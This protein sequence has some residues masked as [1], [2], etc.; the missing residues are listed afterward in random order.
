MTLHDMLTM[1]VDVLSVRYKTAPGCEDLVPTKAHMD[2]AG[3]DLRAREAG[4][5]QQ[6]TWAV[7]STGIFLELPPGYEA[8][9]RGRS[10]LALKQGIL[11]HVGTIDSGYRGEIKVLLYVTNPQ[12]F[13]WERGD[14]I[15]QLVI[16]K[17]PL[18]D[19][20]P[21]EELTDSVRAVAG[22]GSSGIA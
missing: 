18:V 22:F 7:I 11:A 17:I 9:V 20:I 21:A 16:Q 14:R 3:F 4:T 19:L 5:A 10:G 1:R 13:V 15:A 8:Q 2:D 6:N 12:G